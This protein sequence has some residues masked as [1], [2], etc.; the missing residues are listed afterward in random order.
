MKNIYL[1]ISFSLTIFFS[2]NAFA[3]NF[4]DTLPPPATP[5]YRY[6]ESVKKGRFFFY[7][8]YNRAA[9]LSSDIH[10]KGPNYNFTL[11]N[12]VA[13]DR[14]TDF[15]IE[16]YFGLTSVWIP[17]YNY[18]IGYYFSP[19]WG[20]SLGLDHMKYVVSQ[21]QTV[22]LTGNI[23]ANAS[24]KY[25]G[26]YNKSPIVLSEDFLIY[27]H[28]DGLNFLSLDAEYVQ[29]IT[30][31]WKRR[32]RLS[33]Q[34]G[35]GGGPVIPRTD[36]RVFGDGLN[37]NFKVS[38]WGINGKAGLKLDLFKRFF[39]QTQV[40]VGYINLSDI[41]LHN[42]EPQRAKQDI[43]FGEVFGVLGVYF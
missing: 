26:E 32:L 41:L 39:I 43:I 1:L 40:R 14:P 27:E 37:N 24:A 18:R 17:Q 35:G 10:F 11:S 22:N 2:I 16:T 13:A 31:F 4:T 21:N 36:S 3:T 30:D 29:P 15:N 8:G 33:F 23:S 42:D 20:I 34:G 38:G 19:K 25:A 28:T 5:Q 7:W 12:V 6:P 9:F